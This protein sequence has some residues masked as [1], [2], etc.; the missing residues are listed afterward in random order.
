[1]KSAD[2]LLVRLIALFKLLKAALL[3]AVGMSA[4]HLLHRDVASVAEHWVR[5]LGLDPGNRYVDRALQKFADL[6]P[7]K[8]KS[9]GVVSFVYAGLFLIEGIGLW[10]VKR[11]AEWFSVIITTSLVPVE[12]YEIY[13]HPSALKCLVLILNIVV[14]GYL[15]YRIRNERQHGGEHE[16]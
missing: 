5:M 1:M 15:L 2:N 9:L 13:R 10:L 14:V 6:T 3:I 4:L 12:I 8:I 16:S 11:W 7:Q